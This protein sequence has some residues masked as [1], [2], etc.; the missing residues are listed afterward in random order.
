[1][2]LAD[3]AQAKN[4]DYLTINQYK[5]PGLVLMEN[6]GA[7]AARH[8]ALLGGSKYSILCGKGNNGGDGFVVAR[9]LLS[10]G[11]DVSVM[12]VAD[13]SS[14]KG[15]ALANLDML[16]NLGVPIIC[17]I[18]QDILK[19][20]DIIV[21]ALLGIGAKG[22]PRGEVADAI[23][24]INA[25]KKKVLSVDVPSGVDAS[26]GFVPGKCVCA[27]VTVTFG[28]NKIGLVVYPGAQYAGRVF[29]E[30]ISFALQAVES[31]NINI[32][33]IKRPLLPPRCQNSHKG[34]FGKVLAICGSEEY[35]GA[36]YLSSMAA[37]K[38]GCGLVN[39]ITPKSAY[40]PLAQKLTEVIIRPVS[41]KDG[42]IS[43]ASLNTIVSFAEGANSIICGCGL[44]QNHDIIE[45]VRA[46]AKNSKVPIIL[47][48]DGLNAAAKHIDILK[49]RK[50]E[51]VVTPHLGEMSRLTGLSVEEIQKDIVLVAKNF[52]SEYNIV[53]VL[54]SAS[55]IVALPDGKAY[56]N[57]IGNSGMAT[58]GSGDV[59]AGL[60][61]GLIA[62]GL[63]PSYAAVSG[64]FLHARAGDIA[65]SKL[66]EHGTVASDIL[67]AIPFA[68]NEGV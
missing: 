40:I 36:A 64:V 1:M 14:I 2:K 45:V 65:A 56:I 67:A 3:A 10:Q 37:I 21:D 24:A 46:V 8:A 49:N 23:D 59:L 58:A 44:G 25:A 66:G 13:E 27:D 57:T 11:F 61:G 9:H 29:V 12:L 35:T 7:A 33:T 22:A 41:D 47:D 39:L 43:A 4:I 26:T 55:T 62:Q 48:A 31:Q 53:T 32:E 42:K 16:K 6:A 20:C 15:D 60:I 18:N 34:S 54:K 17:G 68:I 5:I 52:A 51:M 50:A 19:N 38:A 28:V 63:S 30:E